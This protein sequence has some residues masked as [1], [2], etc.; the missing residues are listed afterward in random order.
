[1]TIPMVGVDGVRQTV[2]ADL[3]T[4]Q[5]VWNLRSALNV[6]ALNCM[7]AEHGA[8]LP[9][10]TA[11]L[12]RY[13]SKLSSTNRA[14]I[15]EFRAEYGPGFRDVQDSYMTRVYNYFALPP[16]QENFCDVALAVSSEALAPEVTDLE[17]FAAQA[18]PRIERE[19]ETFF[20]A[21][22][23][24]RTDLAAWDARYG[25]SRSEVRTTFY[26]NPDG[27]TT[28]AA[29]M[30]SSSADRSSAGGSPAQGELMIDLSGTTGQEPTA[31][32]ATP[33]P[34]SD[35]QPQP[36]PLPRQGPIILPEE[37]LQSPGSNYATERN[38]EIAGSE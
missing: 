18:L 33:V 30:G 6:A 34:A 2:N 29:S 36:A 15:A 12:D 8:L 16:A 37:T 20:S 3:S 35:A 5:T 13:A 22:E 9:N 7:T 10:Y 4:A 24:Y 26:G 19:F 1:M 31:I 25:P 11:F 28:G 32:E 27:I 21:Y 23:Q 38:G 17:L 14:L